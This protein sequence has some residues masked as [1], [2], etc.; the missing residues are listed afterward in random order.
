MTIP[1]VELPRRIIETGKPGIKLDD[2]Q[3]ALL[4][5]CM[6]LDGSL[7]SLAEVVSLAD[8]IALWLKEE[9]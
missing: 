8:R 4:G 5:A 3:V 2:R 1:S 6:F 9:Q 7:A